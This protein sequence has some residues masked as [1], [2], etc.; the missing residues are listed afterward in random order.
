MNTTTWPM[1]TSASALAQ[2]VVPTAR[3]IR[4]TPPLV[5]AGLLL[6]RVMTS[7]LLSRL[8][9]FEAPLNVSMP[10]DG[11]VVVFAAGVTLVA[12]LL[13]GLAPALHASR[14]DVVSALKDESQ[15]PTDR[16]RLRSAFV[17]AQIA[18]SVLLV[19]FYQERPNPVRNGLR[20]WVVYRIS[21][22]ALLLAAVVLHHTA[23]KGDFDRLMGAGPWPGGS[24]SLSQSGLA[25]ICA[26]LL[27]AAAGK[28]VGKI[29]WDPEDIVPEGGIK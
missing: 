22:A 7:L 1:T 6:G 14:A 3:A 29:T 18:L 2:A 20:V 10:L 28:S 23:G 9:A 25:L 17:V 11:R 5:M 19:G 4:W 8:P 12:A 13:S 21:D 24:A 27:I 16:L 26:L 15:G